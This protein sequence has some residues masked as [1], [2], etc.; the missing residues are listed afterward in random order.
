MRPS[1]RFLAM[2]LVTV[3][4]SCSSTNPPILKPAGNNRVDT[5]IYAERSFAALARAENSRTAFLAYLSDSSVIFRPGPV[6]GITA[7]TAQPVRPLLLAWEPMY[8]DVS[9]SGEFGYTTGPASLTPREYPDS[10]LW[11]GHFVSFWSKNRYGEWRVL[12]DIGTGNGP[13]VAPPAGLLTGPL[14][15]LPRRGPGETCSCNE[16]VEEAEARFNEALHTAPPE[17]AYRGV[18]AGD[19]RL[20]RDGRF[21]VVGREMAIAALSDSP[22]KLLCEPIRAWG[23]AA[24]DLG[25]SYGEYR[26]QEDEQILEHG[27]YVRIWRSFG[28]E[29]MH[30][31]LDLLSPVTP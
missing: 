19:A 7:V 31:V 8:A 9:T 18:L 14:S 23:S 27:Y 26:R 16:S 20:Y 15:T 28:G 24:G 3:A 5:L 1:A 25:C 17:N 10:V 22:G 29:R 30:L 11:Y 21:P 2:A 13:S 4:L 12:L 6:N